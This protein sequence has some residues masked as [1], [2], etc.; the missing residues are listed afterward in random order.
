MMKTAI[1]IPCYNESMTIKKVINDFQKAL[2]DADIYVYDNN[3]TTAV[4]KQ[5]VAKEPLKGMT[6]SKEKEMWSD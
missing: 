4:T 2:P 3:Q 1:L 6:T 5:Q